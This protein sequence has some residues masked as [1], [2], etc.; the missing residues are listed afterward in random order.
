MCFKIDQ[1]TAEDRNCESKP[2]SELI[3]KV[4]PNLKDNI[5]NGY[6]TTLTLT[7]KAVDAINNIMVTSIPSPPTKLNSA[8]IWM[9]SGTKVDSLLSTLIHSIPIKYLAT[10]LN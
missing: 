4:F 10:A 1:N 5:H 7:N 2:M 9:I 8:A 6:L 3:K